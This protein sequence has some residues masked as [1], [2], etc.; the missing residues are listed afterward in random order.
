M[1]RGRQQQGVLFSQVQ[2]VGNGHWDRNEEK[3]ISQSKSQSYF[4]DM[5]KLILKVYEESK[6]PRIVNTILKKNKIGRLTLPNFKTYYK[7]T[8]TK[9]VWYW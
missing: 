2:L 8:I 3:R 6:R 9:T 7:A 4:V 1:L 5:N